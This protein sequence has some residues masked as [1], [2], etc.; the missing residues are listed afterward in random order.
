MGCCA[1]STMVQRN[2]KTGLQRAVVRLLLTTTHAVLDR[3]TARVFPSMSYKDIVVWIEKHA[4]EP[5]SIDRKLDKGGLMT[6]ATALFHSSNEFPVCSAQMGRHMRSRTRLER[7]FMVVPSQPCS[8]LCHHSG[9]Q[10]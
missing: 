5:L 9:F 8:T 7:R 1:P 10:C 2:I 3:D 4:T 6:K